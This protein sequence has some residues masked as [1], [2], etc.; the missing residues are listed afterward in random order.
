LPALQ[1][2]FQLIQTKYLPLRR[3]FMATQAAL[4]TGKKSTAPHLQ[5]IVGSKRMK[6]KGLKQNGR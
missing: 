5:H 6:G 1:I 2:S 3:D 4:R